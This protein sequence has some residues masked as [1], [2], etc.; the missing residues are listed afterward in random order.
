MGEGF[1]PLLWGWSVLLSLFVLDRLCRCNAQVAC[2]RSILP[3]LLLLGGLWLKPQWLEL[4]LRCQ[5][6]L[7][8]SAPLRFFGQALRLTLA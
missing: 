8:D 1:A 6:G 7:M 5:S 2:L 3:P 4:A